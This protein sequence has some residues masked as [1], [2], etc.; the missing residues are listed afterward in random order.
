[1]DWWRGRSRPNANPEGL[2]IDG[3]D[4]ADTI[5][6]FAS[7][8]P[9]QMTRPADG[10]SFRLE[11][12]PGYDQ[13]VRKTIGI[14]LSLGGNVVSVDLNAEAKP[15]TTFIIYDAALAEAEPTDNAVFGAITIEIP[16]VRLGGVDETI[17]LGTNYLDGVDLT[18]PDA[19]APPASAGGDDRMSQASA[20]ALAVTAAR[21]AD[22][23]KAERTL[24][25]FVGDVLSITDYFVI[26]SASNRRLVRMVVE[27]IELAVREQH[28]RSPLRVEGV[29]EQQWVLIDYG[30]AVI[31]VFSDE[32]R[33]YYEIE[34]LYRDVPKI[35]WQ[36]EQA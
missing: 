9:A 12:P 18:A 26:T 32:I 27:E 28:G 16:D 14:L 8:A 2:D 10:L 6:V 24:V 25:L 1:M 29:A 3:L 21:T 17:S 30:D 35:D 33:A 23:K 19:T 4:R 31:H 20:A 7:I 11:A 5:L 15:E 22:D 13:Q 34:R 36:S